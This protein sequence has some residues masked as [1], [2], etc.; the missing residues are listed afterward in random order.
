ML[1]NWNM[2]GSSRILSEEEKPD[3]NAVVHD[4]VQNSDSAVF[5]TGGRTRFWPRDLILWLLP[6][7]L[8]AQVTVQSAL[9]PPWGLGGIADFRQHRAAPV[10]FAL[11]LFFF[12]QAYS[13]SKSPEQLLEI[14]EMLA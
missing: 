14:G 10:A 5:P 9:L 1:E 2:T 8:V 12:L 7:M 11:L 13:N 3:V 4:A 6:I